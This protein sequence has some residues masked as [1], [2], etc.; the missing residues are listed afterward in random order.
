MSSRYHRLSDCSHQ[1]ERETLGYKPFQKRSVGRCAWLLEAGCGLRSAG[2]N[3]NGHHRAVEAI[4]SQTHQCFWPELGPRQQLSFFQD[5]S[6]QRENSH[7]LLQLG[8]S[9]RQ[10]P[11]NVMQA[12]SIFI[13]R[14]CGKRG[15]V[16]GL[17]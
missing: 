14:K 5:T 10:L 3:T 7:Q 8:R 6:Q 1:E 17:C 15:K 13:R 9:G 2:G 16:Q 4:T 12:L 11:R